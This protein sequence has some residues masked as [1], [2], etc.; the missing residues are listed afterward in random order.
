M[1]ALLIYD[2]TLASKQW[3]NSSSK[4]LALEKQ[5]ISSIFFPQHQTDARTH[6][7][8]QHHRKVWPWIHLL[9][10]KYMEGLHSHVS[11]AHSSI[12][13]TWFPLLAFCT[14][15]FPLS[16]NGMVNIPK[17]WQYSNRWELSIPHNIKLKKDIIVNFLITENLVT[18]YILQK[19][20]FPKHVY[21]PYSFF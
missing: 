21:I 13:A 12:K 2:S 8:L 6:Q 20:Y 11:R 1:F 5:L 18:I 4:P 19:L 9:Q 10:I 16:E 7:K 14:L 3:K 17:A 15:L